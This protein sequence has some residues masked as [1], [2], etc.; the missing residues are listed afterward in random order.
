MSKDDKSDLRETKRPDTSGAPREINVDEVDMERMKER[1]TDLPALLEYAHSV[2]GFA[3][4]PT[5]HGK[6]KGQAM[7]AMKEQTEMHMD[8]LYDQMKLLATQAQ[9][10]K[11]RAELSFEIY[12]A[13]MGF[14]PLIGKIYYLYKKEDKKILS[15]ISPD[16]WGKTMPF[17]N[18]LAKVKLLSDHTWNILEDNTENLET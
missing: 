15:I 16:E 1:T 2:G 4:V 13:N 11:R 14:K 9:K 18:F 6:I 3:V 10:L 17:D 12:E 8:Q 7:N 5:E